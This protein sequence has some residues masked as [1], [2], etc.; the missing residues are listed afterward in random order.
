ML[1]AGLCYWCWLD[2]FCTS[3]SPLGGGP[4][5]GVLDIG[6]FLITIAPFLV[7]NNPYL[8]L[9]DGSTSIVLI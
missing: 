4:A 9:N 7:A 5:L 8:D 3:I 2:R 6:A 1:L